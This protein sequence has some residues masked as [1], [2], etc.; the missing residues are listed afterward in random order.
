M[1]CKRGGDDVAKPSCWLGNV[2]LAQIGL[3]SWKLTHQGAGETEDAPII[4]TTGP[5]A[6]PILWAPGVSI[7]S[8]LPL[9]KSS[10]A[11]CIQT[12]GF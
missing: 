4:E 2:A 6:D 11:N 12:Q 10:Q 9:P 5:R 7:P 8:S 3:K 1:T